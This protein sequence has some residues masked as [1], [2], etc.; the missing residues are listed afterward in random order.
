MKVILS[1]IKKAILGFSILA[2]MFALYLFIVAIIP[3]VS[4]P[5]Q[6]LKKV[7][8]QTGNNGQKLSGLKRE[9]RFGVK[10]TLLSAW[11]Y[12]PPNLSGPAPCIV[13]GHGL[14]GT[15]D[16][17]LEAY[18]A[19][20]QEAGF[21]V[22]AFDNRYFGESEGEPRQLIW[23]P[24]Q[25]EDWSAAISYVRSLKEIAPARIALGIRTPKQTI[26]GTELAGEVE[27]VGKNVKQFK[28]GD[29]VFGSTIEHNFGAYAEYICLPEAGLVVKRSTKL[30]CEDA[31]TIPVGGR[32]ALYFLRAANIRPGQTALIY[33]ASGSVG[34]FAV[35]LAKYFG[36]EVT[37]VCSTTNLEMEFMYR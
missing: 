29:Q 28:A 10:G 11:L 37:G 17:G 14:G 35:Q 16:M 26:L 1:L 3:G 12:L 6:P 32:T 33:G 20:F 30:S 4:A 27:A 5:A 34:T 31:A 22:L 24:D 13:M 9:V 19:R 25:L 7:K 18:A 23:I 2:G 21:A 8:R 15:K 36:A